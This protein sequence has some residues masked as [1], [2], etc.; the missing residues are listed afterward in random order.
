MACRDPKCTSPDLPVVAQ[1]FCRRCYNRMYARCRRLRD[2]LQLD[3]LCKKDARCFHEGE[4]TKRPHYHRGNC[5]SCYMK[6]LRKAKKRGLYEPYKPRSRP[7][8]QE[9][10]QTQETAIGV[11]PELTQEEWEQVRAAAAVPLPVPKPPPPRPVVS[12]EEG[13]R[14]IAT[15]IANLNGRKPPAPRV[16]QHPEDCDWSDD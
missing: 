3:T 14:Q 16:S 2:L 13:A 4:T 10:T 11:I 15:V 1:G 8:K 6:Q 7:A 12:K 9:H 5:R